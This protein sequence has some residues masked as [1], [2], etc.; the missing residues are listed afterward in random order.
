MRRSRVVAFPTA[1]F[2][3]LHDDT[4]E[5]V[6]LA[7]GP[8]QNLRLDQVSDVYTLGED[9]Q[10]GEVRAREGLGQLNE[11]QRKPSRFGPVGGVAGHTIPSVGLGLG[12]M[13]A[14]K[15]L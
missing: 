3:S 2:I 13:P 5:R 10:R 7:E 12:R 11:I 14:F 9:A 6:T 15:N 4:G 1:I 8:T